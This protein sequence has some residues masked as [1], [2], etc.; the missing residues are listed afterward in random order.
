MKRVFFLLSIFLMVSCAPKVDNQYSVAVSVT[1]DAS[2][3]TSQTV[4]L[5]TG[6]KG[7]VVAD[8]LALVDG[9]CTFE[10]VVEHPN[11]YSLYLEGSQR[12]LTRIFVESD[13]YTVTINAE[14]PQDVVVE[15]GAIQSFINSFAQK[16]DELYH[17]YKLDSLTKGYPTA[18][19]EQ[20]E[21]IQE[22]YAK[23]QSECDSIQNAY[24]IA[25]P[26]SPYTL[27][28]IIQDL[29]ML[30]YEELVEKFAPFEGLP[31]YENHP[32]AVEIKRVIALVK[33]LQPG[34]QAPDF[35]QNDPD[36][37]PIKFSDIYS[38]NKVTMIDF[39]ASWCSPCRQFNPDLVKIYKK[40]H[41]K[42]FEILGVSM[43]TKH[44]AWVKAIKDDKLTWPN[45]SDLNG[46]DNV[47]GAAFYVRYIPQ[48]IIVDQTGKIIGRQ[49]E[50]DQLDAFLAEH[51]K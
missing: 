42:G 11:Y 1:G 4:I 15:G 8:T 36:G 48:N 51:L 38:K 14:N 5:A 41:K 3:L 2:Q 6:L 33:S 30:S 47:V 18:S 31:E 37:K 27:S 28:T 34:E 20:K 32:S 7:N 19:D 40:Y 39:W 12:P 21:Q 29:S 13:D 16:S 43:D 23:W 22:V 44:D 9:K 50:K 45:V 46:W 25:N 49:V 10:G 26:T 24:L 35:E 17:A